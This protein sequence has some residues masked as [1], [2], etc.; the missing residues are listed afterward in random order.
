MSNEISTEV[1]TNFASRLL[2]KAM[3]E[4]K[5][6]GEATKPQT[7]TYAEELEQKKELTTAAKN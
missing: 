4:R 5:K 3:S 7:T 1:R 6:T 2:N